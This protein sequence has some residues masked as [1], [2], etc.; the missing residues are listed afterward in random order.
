MRPRLGW[1]TSCGKPAQ[2]WASASREANLAL[3]EG[4]FAE[5]ERAIHEALE[6]GRLAQSANAQVAFDLQMYALRREQGRLQRLVDVVER[7]VRDYPEYPVWRFV[8]AD[9]FAEL[10]R[11]DDARA[12]FDVCAAD[13]FQL[14]LEEQWLF[15][16]SLS[17]DACRYLGDV[18]RAAALYDLL[19]PYGRRNPTVPTELCRGSVSRNLG[20]LAA[21]SSDW[22]AGSR[23]FRGRPRAELG[24]GRSNLGCPHQVRLRAHAPLP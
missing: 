13:G 19:R 23:A 14:N 15:S 6:L 1:R 5:A 10:D 3:F 18:E 9:V 17:A 8:R 20:T 11:R 7:A 24:D 21:V 12:A 22:G 16:L 2:L 4:R